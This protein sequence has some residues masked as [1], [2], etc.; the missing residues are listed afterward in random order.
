MSQT[1][2]RPF[3]VTL[4]I[5]VRPYD[6]DFLGIVHN[7]VYIRWL[8]DYRPHVAEGGRPGTLCVGGRFQRQRPG[9]SCGRADRLLHQ[10]RYPSPCAH[11]SGDQLGPASPDRSISSGR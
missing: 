2:P 5:P 8:E 11:A 4:T 3:E 10:P 9:D 1:T 6:V 7:L